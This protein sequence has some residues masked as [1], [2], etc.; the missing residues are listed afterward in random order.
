LILLNQD[1]PHDQFPP[2]RA[3]HADIF[4]LDCAWAQHLEG[5]YI[6]RAALVRLPSPPR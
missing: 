6:P 5:S 1:I 3:L 4:K 2:L